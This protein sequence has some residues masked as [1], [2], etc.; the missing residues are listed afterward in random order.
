M[1]TE[2]TVI[3]IGIG[4]KVKDYILLTKLRLSSL[5]IF[6]SAIGYLIAPHGVT[7]WVKISWLLLGGLLTTSG[8]NALNQVIEKD[9]D[10]LMTRTANRPLPTGRMSVTEALLAA[11]ICGVSGILILWCNF[12]VMAALLSAVALL[13]YA[14]IY[15]PLKRISPIAVFV[16]AIPGALP[17]VIGWVAA[18]G[19]FSSEAILLFAIQFLW[20]FPHFWAIAWV[21]YDDYIKAG[22]KL[23]PSNE[24][25]NKFSALQ[26]IIYILVLIPV[27]IIPMSMHMTGWVSTTIVLFA[28][29]LFLIPAINLYR[30]CSVKA[31]RQLMFMSF[32]YLPIVQL[33]LLMK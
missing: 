30:E 5:V 27:S 33:A 29:V 4:Q 22:F 20:Q 24:G 11:G 12:N 1:L 32:F 8:A 19:S 16:G 23:L 31:A 17:P 18:T 21:C 25:R 3:S 13:S 6:S 2:R 28:G 9:Y 14:F 15:T 7:N 26:N 10:K